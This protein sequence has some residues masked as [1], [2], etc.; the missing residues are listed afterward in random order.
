MPH[1]APYKGPS[2]PSE[3]LKSVPRANVGLSGLM[4]YSP[5]I[6]AYREPFG[7]FEGRE[8]GQST[9]LSTAGQ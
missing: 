5:I 6:E 3:T 1:Q 8:S 4:R 9:G 2:E 7:P